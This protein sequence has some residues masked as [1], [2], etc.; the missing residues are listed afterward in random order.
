MNPSF[1]VLSALR[2]PTNGDCVSCRKG[3]GKA[4]KGN[5]SDE[6]GDDSDGSEQEEDRKQSNASGGTDGSMEGVSP[7]AKKGRKIKRQRRDS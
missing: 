6:E 5:S 7:K 4:K 3:K 1:D 2:S